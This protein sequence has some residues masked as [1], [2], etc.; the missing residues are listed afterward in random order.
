MT[1]AI[2]KAAEDRRA[3]GDLRVAPATPRAALRPTRPGAGMA[4]A[5]AR[6]PRPGKI[7]I[8]K[9]AQA[10]RARCR[11][12]AAGRG[13]L[14]RLPGARQRPLPNTIRS[15]W[16]TASTRSGIEGRRPRFEIVDHARRAPDIHVPARWATPGNITAYLDAAISEYAS[17]DGCARGLPRM[18]GFQAAGA[19]RRSSW[20]R[21]SPQSGDHRHRDPHRQPGLRG[22]HAVAARDESGGLDRRRHRREDPRGLPAAR[23]PAKG[24]SASRQALLAWPG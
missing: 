9:L 2:S 4:C 11:G 20:V 21:R 19:A 18:W 5:G 3:G 8:G 12:L 24:C 14:R 23:P 10:L 22:T 17:D 13:Q 1:L 6:S 15:P 7:A 16:S